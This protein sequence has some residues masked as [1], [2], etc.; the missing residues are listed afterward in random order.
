MRSLRFYV[1]D[2]C[3]LTTSPVREKQYWLKPLRRHYFWDL[4]ENARKF[5]ERLISTPEAKYTDEEKHRME[6]MIYDLFYTVFEDGDFGFWE[7][8]MARICERMA[9]FSV[10]LGACEQAL[11]ELEEMCSHFEKFYAFS[12]IDHTSP[13]VRDIHY[14]R[15]AWHDR[16]K[17]VTGKAY[18]ERLQCP[19]Y[20]ALHDNPR[21]ATILQRLE[22]LE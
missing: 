20:N 15:Q 8:R 21:F 1:R 5:G 2:I 18:I 22:A 4:C 16:E 17:E 3:Y 10:R 13:F 6:R 12:S 11:N 9:L 14:A 7:A 19:T